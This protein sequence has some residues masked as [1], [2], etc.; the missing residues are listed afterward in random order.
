MLLTAL[1][2][3]AAL[4]AAMTTKLLRNSFLVFLIPLIAYMSVEKN[5]ANIK[6]KEASTI[7]RII[8]NN[9]HCVS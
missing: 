7:S 2:L 8:L 9:Y 5:K 4:N 3:E 6:K 1:V